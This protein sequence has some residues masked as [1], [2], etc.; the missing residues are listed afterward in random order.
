MSTIDIITGA[1]YGSEGKGHVTAQLVHRYN[2]DGE[3]TTN[4][5]VAGPNAGHTV[6]DEGGM[7]FPLRTI[8]VGAAINHDADL[9]IAPGS[10]IDLEVLHQEIL[11]LRQAGHPVRNLYVSGEA[12]LLTQ[13]HKDRE[14]EMDMHGTIGSTGKGIGAARADRIMRTG[15][16]IIDNWEAR[17]LIT[18]L[19]AQI[20]TAPEH[21]LFMA[22]QLNQHNRHILIEGTQG[23]GLGLH[24]GR[25]PQCTSSDA[26]AIDFLGMAGI[27]PWAPGVE[28]VTPWL[29]ARVYPIR[30]A[31][32]SGPLEG[33]TSW[34]QLGLPEE[35]T[36]VTHKVR[37]VG[38]WDAKLMREAAVANGIA[39]H[40]YGMPPTNYNAP[41][42]VALTM[43]DQ[44]IP[45]IHGLSNLDD[46]DDDTQDLVWELIR[47]VESNAGT[48]VGMFTTSADTCIWNEGQ[49]D[50]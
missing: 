36:T 13:K 6:I 9:Y 30:V 15:E 20:L 38:E 18:A 44:K 35:K 4:I 26:R 8:P 22:N 31:G 43:V 5:R 47:D 41:G 37:R 39:V 16:R 46:A 28:R 40:Q 42:R 19:K 21:L 1:Q 48:K 3:R 34:E 24:A 23:Y 27:S 11:T 12:T 25:Y 10:E 49:V 32:N 33:E 45:Q 14:T 7:A 50:W 2:H 29:V 17:T